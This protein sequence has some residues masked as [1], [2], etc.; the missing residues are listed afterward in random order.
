MNKIRN[1]CI[2]AH[3]DH[4]KSTLADRFLEMTHTI[5]DREK[6]EQFLDS[7]DLERERGITIKM[8][9]VSMRFTSGNE[10]FILNLID[11]PGHVDFTYEVS[12]ALAAVEGAILVV[13]ATSGIQAQTLAHLYVALEQNLA[14]VPVVNKIDLRSA[15]VER[16]STEIAALLGITKDLVIPISAKT[17]KNA[18]SVLQAV[19]ERIPPPVALKDSDPRISRALIFDSYFDAHRGVISDV[20]VVDNA[21]TRGDRVYFCQTKVYAQIKEV[22]TYAPKMFPKDVLSSGEIGYV[23]TGIRAPAHCTVGDT[24]FHLSNSSIPVSALRP[25]PGY[26]QPKPMVFANLYP[27]EQAKFLDLKQALEELHLNDAALFFEP[28]SSAALGKGFKI[29][30]LGLLHLDI[31]QERLA[32]EYGMQCLITVPHVEYRL[33]VKG[34]ESKNKNLEKPLEFITITSPEE[35]PDNPSGIDEVLEPWIKLEIVTNQEYIGTIMQLVMARGGAYVNT[36][37]IGSDAAR[38]DRRAILYFSLP[39]REL[40]TDFYDKLKSVSSGY[41][42]LHYEVE[43]WRTVDLAREVF[44]VA[45]ERQ[46]ALTILV[47]RDWQNQRAREVLE[48]LKRE[49]P[50]HLFEIRLQAAI[51]GKIIASDRILPL[52]KNVT[53]KL[54]GG[55][56]TRKMKLLKK[57]KKGKKRLAQF[58][59]VEIPNSA[60]RAIL[61][62]SE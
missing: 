6:K 51:G 40:L 55:D 1:F 4:G 39:L 44:L 8:Q 2:I 32:R 20:R 25:L 27:K 10:E 54:Y 21:F 53:A 38:P 52:S 18:A 12:R 36:D 43:Q 57:Q 24:I 14:I 46:D 9:P 5:T 29:G 58:G 62:R 37:Y 17:G 61:K 13:D 15:R 3:I 26:K 28:S 11:T 45:G 7:M 34:Q 60:Y 19:I 47:P 56:V 22:G 35:F 49:I 23:V 48:T 42:S 33:R 30:A 16:V 41:A 50:P 31:V 59:K